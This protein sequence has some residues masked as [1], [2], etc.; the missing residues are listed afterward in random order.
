MLIVLGVVICGEMYY[1]ELVFNELGVGIMCVG[2][3][4][5]IVIVNG[6]L[7]IDIDV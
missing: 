4:F 6:I 7:I 3:D 5:N 2:L 1:F